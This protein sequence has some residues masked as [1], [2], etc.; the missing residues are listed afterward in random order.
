MKTQPEALR[1]AD[2]IDKVPYRGT[3]E[4]AAEL[5]RLHQSE[6]EGWRHADE[7]EQERLRLKA[8]NAELLDTLKQIERG[9]Y[10][11][12]EEAE[13]ARSAIAKAEAA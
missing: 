3:H 9:E 12:G 8:V 11:E 13:M 4:A 7:L 6:R 10:C 2:L 1:L 5:R